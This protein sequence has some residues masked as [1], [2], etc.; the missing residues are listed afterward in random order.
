MSGSRIT[1]PDPLAETFN[2]RQPGPR[3]QTYCS[4]LLAEMED[5]L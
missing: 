1:A 4:V 2:A 5:A 3:F